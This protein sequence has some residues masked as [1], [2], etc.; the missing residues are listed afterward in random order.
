M[1]ALRLKIK[2]ESDTLKIPEL[3]KFIGKRVEIILIDDSPQNLS[4]KHDYSRLK[5]LKG[6]IS[7]DTSALSSL[8]ESSKI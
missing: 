7:F 3:S 6:K 1:N 5:N 4:D 2:I 8:R